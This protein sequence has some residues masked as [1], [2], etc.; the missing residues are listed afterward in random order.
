[1]LANFYFKRIRNVL[2][3]LTVFQNVSEKEWQ[4]DQR[5]NYR[6]IKENNLFLLTDEQGIFYQNTAT[7]LDYIRMIRGT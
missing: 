6:V 7:D 3:F 1:M 2:E 5:M 4:E